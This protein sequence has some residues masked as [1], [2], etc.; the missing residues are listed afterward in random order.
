MRTEDRLATPARK[1]AWRVAAVMLLVTA[2]SNFVQIL[3]NAEGAASRLITTIIIDLVLMVGLWAGV[4]WARTWTLWRAGA[5]AVLF[6]IIL[7]TQ[8]EYAIAVAQFA[9]TG[10]VLLILTGQ[11]S[12]RRTVLSSG[13]F[14]CGILLVLIMP[15]VTATVGA[16]KEAHSERALL[17]KGYDAINRED[18]AAASN[19][20]NAVLEMDPDSALAYNGWGWIDYWQKQYEH[21]LTNYNR[22]IELDPDD[23]GFYVNRCGTFMEL[24]WFEEA[25]A[26]MDRAI[27]LDDSDYQDFVLRGMIHIKLHHPAEA[28]ADWETALKKAPKGADVSEI[29]ALLKALDAPGGEIMS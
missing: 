3:L 5:G 22:A 15:F 11:S 25:L 19:A 18:Y 13:L 21:A 4:S 7:I 20:F 12:T 29:K 17:T 26:D 9:V 1:T 14:A 27:E 23:A 2:I 16:F 24:Q 6:P 28:R 8:H 10:G